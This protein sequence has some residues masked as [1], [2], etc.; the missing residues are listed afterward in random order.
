MSEKAEEEKTV[1]LHSIGQCLENLRER[2]ECLC[3]LVDHFTDSPEWIQLKA[4]IVAELEPYP[5]AKAAILAVLERVN[6]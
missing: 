2:L 4:L 1:T 3:S 6:K 5:E